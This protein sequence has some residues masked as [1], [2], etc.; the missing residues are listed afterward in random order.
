MNK[1]ISAKISALK[2]SKMMSVA[3]PL[4]VALMFSVAPE[5]MAGGATTSG[6]SEFDGVWATLTG[7]MAGTLGK[8]AAGT[9]ILV[10]IIAGIARQNLFAFAA[11]IGGG[12]GLY[13]APSIIDSMFTATVSSSPVVTGVV[14]TISNGM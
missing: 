8:I 7:W 12:I 13:N 3:V 14:T 9:M 2:S 1:A 10:G 5:V 6:G 4:A 11:G